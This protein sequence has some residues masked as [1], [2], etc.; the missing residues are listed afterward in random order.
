MAVGNDT[1]CK[2]P[3]IIMKRHQQ[4]LFFFFS[5]ILPAGSLVPAFELVTPPFRLIAIYP[6]VLNKSYIF[7]PYFA[8]TNFKIAPKPVAYSLMCA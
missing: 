5:L 8:L 6:T 3:T 1:E 7:L 2:E 4:Q